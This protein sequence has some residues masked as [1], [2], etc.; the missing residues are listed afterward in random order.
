MIL[1]CTFTV[2]PMRNSSA[3]SFICSA[4]RAF[5]TSIVV[6]FFPD[7]PQELPCLRREAIRIQELRAELLCFLYALHKPPLAD[8]LMVPREKN[9]R[10][11]HAAKYLRPRI[12]GVLQQA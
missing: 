1:K 9:L 8:L 4:S 12:V 10:H 11:T 5:I 6:S 3:F 7:L 2:S